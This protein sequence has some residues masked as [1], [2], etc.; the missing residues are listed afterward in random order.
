MYKLST[1]TSFLIFL[2]ISMSVHQSFSQNLVIAGGGGL[3]DEIRLHLLSLSEKE[4][5]NVLII[6]HAT[7]EDNWTAR[8]EQQTEVFNTLGAEHV[9]VLELDNR[10]EAIRLIE[11]SDVIWMPGGSQQRLMNALV[12]A[13]V[14]DAVRQHVASGIPTGG[15]SAGAAI[16]SKTM[17][18]N[19][20]RDEETGA[21]LPVMSEGLGFWEEVI[22]DQHF[23]ERNRLE[24][25]EYAVE[26]H[27]GYV[28]IGIDEG[29][30][31]VFDGSQFKVIGE[32]T[33]T[34]V[35]NTGSSVDVRVLD[36]GV[37]VNT[38]GFSGLQK[39]FK[40]EVFA[41][42]DKEIVQQ[43]FRFIKEY[44][45]QTV[46]NQIHI[47][48][49]PAPPFS[50]ERRAARYAEMMR[51]F[52][53]TDVTIDEEGNALGRRPGRSGDRTIVFSAHLDTVFPEET[54]VTVTV[55][56]DTLFAPGISDDG[57]GL[58]TLLTVLKTMEELGIETE[59]DILFV[60]TVG[61]EGLGDLRGVKYLFREDGPQIDAFISVDGS[62]GT[63]IVNQALGSYR[64]RVTF[65]GTGGHSWGAFGTAN[66]A[67]A[68]GR[69]IHHFD[70]MA[71]EY[72]AEGP[73]TSYNVG[74]IGGGTSVNSVPFS[75]WM[76]VDMR[77][78]DQARLYDMDEILKTAVQRGV[79][80]ANE[81]RTRGG[82]LSADLDMI[83]KRPSGDIA[84]SVPFIQRAKAATVYFGDDYVLRRSST[85]SN[86][87]ISLGI[88][89][90]TLGGG[91]SSGGAHSLD[92]W[93]Y[94]N[95][96]HKGIQR[97]FLILLSEVKLA[98]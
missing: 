25:L 8:G 61:E 48:E 68:L 87:S 46:A 35:S 16:M 40:D 96:G 31:V 17:I 62:H 38:E 13:G 72:V 45:D 95:E 77:S 24:R 20:E 32:G 28:G 54:D 21:L 39:P 5:P 51:E 22:I 94:N 86:V 34:V 92:E 11:R 57:R 64:Y 44:D 4:Q 12:E 1:I 69:A 52:G 82:E 81:V 65:N 58:T 18:A 26:N 43:A 55:R 85:D 47:T 41:L 79:D 49:I 78:V 97:A 71:S 37:T 98:E 15:T 76:E 59:D 53:L 23:S 30:A 73:R 7:A 83:G 14:A 67:H 6:P 75:N 66:P 19:S 27:P 84:P 33:V 42:A 60:G 88:P 90:M 93:W 91:G 3:S 80:E 56:N 9:S 63:R 50:E 29:T 70:E 10:E 2:F 89:S 74:R 36:S